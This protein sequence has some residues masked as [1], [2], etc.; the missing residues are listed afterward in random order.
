M[1]AGPIFAAPANWSLL[2]TNPNA[3]SLLLAHPEKIHYRALCTNP[4]PQIIPLLRANLD[5]VHWEFLSS[6]PAIFALDCAKMREQ[7]TPLREELLRHRMHPSRLYQAEHDWL[8][9]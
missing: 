7:M 5:K 4:S 3:V 6:N 2:S 1:A 9:F 8:L